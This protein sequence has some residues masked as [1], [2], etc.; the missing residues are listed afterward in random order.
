MSNHKTSVTY[1]NEHLFSS[2]VCV[3]W[4]GLAGLTHMAEHWLHVC[5]SALAVAGLAGIAQCSPTCTIP[6]GLAQ[7]VLMEQV[8]MHKCFF[9]ALLLTSHWSK[10][11]TRPNSESR[12]G[13]IDS[14]SSVRG[15]A[16]SHRQGMALG[17]LKD[18]ED[19]GNLLCHTTLS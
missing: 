13:E 1:N 16:E 9:K 3:A 14:T 6:T 11:V 10:Q 5:W 2:Q 18:W 7:H 8:E 19:E 17:G 15:T 12:N 4:W